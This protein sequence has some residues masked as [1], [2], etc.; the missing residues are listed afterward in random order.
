M[1]GIE[2]CHSLIAYNLYTEHLDNTL[3]ISSSSKLLNRAQNCMP[4]LSLLSGHCK[5][6]YVL[7]WDGNVTH[8]N[9]SLSSPLQS[10]RFPSRFGSSQQQKQ[11]HVGRK[12]GVE[13]SD[14]D[15]LLETKQMANCITQLDIRKTVLLDFN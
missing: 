12:S 14:Q 2:I 1:Q 7:P 13:P 3:K 8:V 4:V 15:N 9:S 11:L 6:N 10:Q 5:A